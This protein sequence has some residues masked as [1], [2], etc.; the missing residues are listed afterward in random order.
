MKPIPFTH[1]PDGS[2]IEALNAALVAHLLAHPTLMDS[3]AS[4]A[5]KDGRHSG[6]LLIEPK[7]PVAALE[8]MIHEAVAGYGRDDPQTAGHPFVAMR[9]ERYQLSVWGVVLTG[10]GHQVPHIHPSAWLSGVYYP[11]VPKAVDYD[12]DG[13]AGWI[14]FGRPPAHVHCR[15]E[16]RTV[17]YRPE[18][19]LMLLFPSYLYHRTIPFTG[20]EERVSIAFDVRP[21]A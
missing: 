3:P 19:G 4:H 11:K 15:K 17:A 21:A 1:A 5:T 6:E 20:D 10:P 16:P 9:P 7:G 12:G 13:Q 14:E 8:A 18:E 2:D